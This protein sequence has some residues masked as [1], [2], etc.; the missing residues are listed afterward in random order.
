MPVALSLSTASPAPGELIPY[1]TQ[2]ATIGVRVAQ[3]GQ[4][5][6]VTL[7]DYLSVVWLRKWLVVV[8]VTACT[9]TA[10]GLSYVISPRYTATTL[11]MYEPPTNIAN[12]LSTS[13]ST[14]VNE[15]T[16]QTQS[17][18]NTI[19]SPTVT[20]RAQAI[21]GDDA[22]GSYEVQAAILPPDSSS[23]ASVSDVVAV[24][25]EGND[26]TLAAEAA[27]AYAQAVIDTR[28]ASQQERYRAAQEAVESQ[29][30]Q[31]QTA[32]SKLST[33]YLL[34]AQRLRDL[35]VAE[36]TATGDFTVIS[37]ATPPTAPSSPKPLQNGVVAFAL[38]LFVG[39]GMAFIVSQFDTRVRTHREVGR[40]LNL[41]VLARVPRIA[42]QALH[43]GELVT[44]SAPAGPVAESLRMLRSN[45]NW[46]ALDADWKSLLVTSGTKGEGKT[47][48]LCNLAVVMAL[49]GKKVIVVDADLRAPRVHRAFSMSD[50]SKGLTTVLK[51]RLSWSQ[52]MRPYDLDRRETPLVRV[53]AI[54]ERQAGASEKGALYVL[55]SGPTPPNPGELVASSEFAG[56]IRAI[57]ES[58]VDYVLV[59]APPALTT[60]DAAALAQLVDGL[61]F[62]VNLRQ[63]RRP[64]LEDCREVLDS[65]PCRK[66]GAVIVG[67]RMSRSGY[68][69]YGAESV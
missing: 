29:M 23:G 33:D 56:V 49:S 9:V 28:L 11:L 4:S 59:D 35:Q 16:L 26:A 68:Y 2:T 14:D 40:I 10:V 44:I 24:S 67:E 42:E 20:R 8:V 32:E 22:S 17:V 66:L 55:S 19:N 31:Y 25:A 46:A 47:L 30:R 36:A 13:S 64:V 3:A 15:L 34:L 7:R 48:T 57:A 52:V 51:E 1:V 65:M 12:P 38:S 69:G 37:P 27:N 58:G 61:L 6:S 54:E 50:N 45:L 62:V 53:P 60:G 39:V 43:D 18:V 63:L 21:L 41:P 5:P